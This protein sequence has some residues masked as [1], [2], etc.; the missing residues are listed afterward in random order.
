MN[1]FELPHSGWAQGVIMVI[2]AT[3]ATGYKRPVTRLSAWTGPFYARAAQNFWLEL[4]HT[5]EIRGL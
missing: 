2:N 4:Y 5:L 3:G 1:T